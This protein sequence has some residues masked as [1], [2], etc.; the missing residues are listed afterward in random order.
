M[1]IDFHFLQF[2]ETQT[3]LKLR[4]VKSFYQSLSNIGEWEITHLIQKENL[5]QYLTVFLKFIT[6]LELNILRD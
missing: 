3:H 4:E 2:A 6:L 1:L 5:G